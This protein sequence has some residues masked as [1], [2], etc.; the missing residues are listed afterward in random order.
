MLFQAV[1]PSSRQMGHQRFHGACAAAVPG[2]KCAC[3][4]TCAHTAHH[5]TPHLG[6]FEN[7]QLKQLAAIMLRAAPFFVMIPAKTDQ[8]DETPSAHHFAFWFMAATHASGTP[9]MHAAITA[10][11]SSATVKHPWIP[12]ILCRCCAFVQRRPATPLQTIWVSSR[13]CC[14]RRS[15]S[16]SCGCALGQRLATPCHHSARL[17]TAGAMFGPFSSPLGSRAF[18][19]M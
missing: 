14:S 18:H 15:G 9:R 7:Q 6:A 5:P 1:N 11:H 4:C 3:T 13:Y 2:H 12:D 19:M 16:G 17:V 10:V 8:G